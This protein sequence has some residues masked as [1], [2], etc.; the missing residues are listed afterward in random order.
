MGYQTEFN[1]EFKVKPTLR[2]EDFHDLRLFSQ[3]DHREENKGYPGIWCQWVP[4][5]DGTAIV[6]DGGEKFY[7]YVEW[8]K[9]LLHIY[10]KPKGYVLNGKMHWCGEEEDDKGWIIVEDNHIFTRRMKPIT[11]GPKMPWL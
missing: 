7:N 11:Y 4:N 10:L 8:L 1:G 2:Q 6:W 3:E 9:Y 5:D